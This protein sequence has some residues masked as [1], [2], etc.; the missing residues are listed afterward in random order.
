MF[1]QLEIGNLNTL[2][3]NGEISRSNINIDRRIFDTFDGYCLQYSHLPNN[4]FLADPA[5][6]TMNAI[7]LVDVSDRNSADMQERAIRVG[8]YHPYLPNP[9]IIHCTDDFSM[10]YY[11]EYPDDEIQERFGVDSNDPPSTEM[12]FGDL[13]EQ[14][15]SFVRVDESLKA[16][17]I[18]RYTLNVEQ[19]GY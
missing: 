10:V 6:G 16:N 19:L 9:M 1:N 4:L 8:F 15:P 18:R 3:L 5:F 13:L 17:I 14:Y 7:V 12:F 2:I 11:M